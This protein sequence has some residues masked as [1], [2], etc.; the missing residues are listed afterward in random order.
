MPAHH[1]E[2]TK[3]TFDAEVTNFKGVVLVDFWA[4]WCGPCRAMAPRIDALAEK[5][6]DD[7][8]V[9]IAKVDVDAEPELSQ[10]QQIF[11][12]PTFKVFANG[13]F[14][15]QVPGLVPPTTLE[16]LLLKGLAK[17]EP[18]AA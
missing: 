14:V 12:L 7:S 10:D 11:S 18:V 8:R 5:Y 6:A 13:V 9:K 17:L 3:A 4:A 15:D 1:A 16:E 2:L